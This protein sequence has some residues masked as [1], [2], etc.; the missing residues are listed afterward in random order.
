MSAY[1]GNNYLPL[2][3]GFYRSHRSALFTLVDSLELE[4]TTAD[5]SV[6]DAVEFIRANRDRCSD[7]IPVK[8]THTLDG[9]DITLAVDVE[10]FASTAWPRC[11]A[12]GSGRG[13]SRG[14][15]WRCACS[16]RW[17]LSCAPGMWR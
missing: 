10:G 11:C 5:R 3:G 7:W 17:P 8:T 12:T 14:G 9:R 13:C 4:P 1:H 15:T 6:L 16:P 2:L